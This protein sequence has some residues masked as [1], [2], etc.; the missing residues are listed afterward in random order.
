MKFH[1][2]SLATVAIAVCC[3]LG[4]TESMAGGAIYAP[5]PQTVYP[6]ST[7]YPSAPP[8]YPAVPGYAVPNPNVEYLAPGAPPQPQQ[9]I[10]I[11][12]PGPGYAWTAGYWHWQNGWIWIPG[13]WVLPPRPGLR[14]FGPHWEHHDDDRFRMEHGGWR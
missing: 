4:S 13:Q 6:Y 11:A 14:W 8:A 5:A 2:Y 9:E 1:T 12:S 10:I 7:G 3:T